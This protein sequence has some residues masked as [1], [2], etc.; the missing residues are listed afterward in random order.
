MLYLQSRTLIRFYNNSI[1][2]LAN[3]HFECT[4]E[5]Q[6]ESTF[7]VMSQDFSTTA[8]KIKH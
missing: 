3:Q 1:C 2:E 8:G 4:Q 5:D 6:S 7:F